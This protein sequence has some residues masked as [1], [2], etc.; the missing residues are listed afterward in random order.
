MKQIARDTGVGIGTL[1]R[2]FPTRE[3]LVEAIPG[4]SSPNCAPT[5]RRFSGRGIGP[6]TAQLNGPLRRLRDDAAREHRRAAWR[7]HVQRRDRVN[8]T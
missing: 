3:A 8:G 4:T 7:S 6:R 1:Y 5:P 2:H